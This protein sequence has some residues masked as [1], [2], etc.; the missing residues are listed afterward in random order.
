VPR[1]C[2]FIG[3][4]LDAGPDVDR[5]ATIQDLTAMNGFATKY[6]QRDQHFLVSEVGSYVCGRIITFRSN[7]TRLLA[8]ERSL[9]VLLDNV[10]TDYSEI[11]VNYF[12][13]HSRTL[14]GLYAY[15]AQSL[16]FNDFG[17]RLM[18]VAKRA[19][20][21]SR[22]VA[23]KVAREAAKA[24]GRGDF[25]AAERKAIDERFTLTFLPLIRRETLDRIIAEWQQI[26]AVKYEVA[27][28]R[29][30]ASAYGAL[31]PHTLADVRE[32]RLDRQVSPKTYAGKIAGYVWGLKKQFGDALKKTTLIGLNAHGQLKRADLGKVVD[33]FADS[34]LDDVIN[35]AEIRNTD[36]AQS[37]VIRRMIAEAED[38][39][40]YFG[41][42]QI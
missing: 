18:R 24:A 5:A 28:T 19:A 7:Q 34:P 41:K 30:D 1:K 14:H 42:V 39:P 32:L 22:S 37:A 9:E 27:T 36:L 15:Y 33:T 40:D 3:F 8:H 17:D 12:V 26:T 6:K 25:T 13:F 35:H 11:A 10:P 4:R 16:P 21:T 23:R 31:A 2:R 38:R 20:A 29:P